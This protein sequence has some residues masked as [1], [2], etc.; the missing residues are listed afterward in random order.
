MTRRNELR[1]NALNYFLEHGLAELSLRPLAEHIGTSARLLIYHFDSKE[2]LITAVMEEARSRVQQSVM[3]MMHAAQG[4]ASMESFWG[5]V[6]DK[7]NIRYV[8][9]LFEVQVL[10]L[11]NPAIYAQFLSDTSS[12]WLEVIEYGIPE[13]ADRRTIATLCGAVI[14]GLVLDYMNTGDLD[15]TT[16]ALK[17]FVALL[18]QDSSKFKK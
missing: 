18:S 8:R 15:R 7:E 13:S 6:T 3:A 10:A 11:Q 9:L 12:S 16:A 2:K 17:F 5:W 4:E 14:D 1:D